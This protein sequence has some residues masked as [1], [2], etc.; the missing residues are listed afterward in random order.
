MPLART[1]IWRQFGS[2]SVDDRR[3]L[4]KAV[5]EHVVKE[6]YGPLDG[7][8]PVEH[9]QERHRKCLGRLDVGRLVDRRICHERLR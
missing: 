1:A 3:Y 7:V 4:I 5:A 2:S 9:E 6:E 8:Q